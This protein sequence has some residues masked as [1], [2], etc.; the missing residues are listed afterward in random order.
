[1]SQTKI[2][3]RQGPW[4]AVWEG[5]RLADVFH[6]SKPDALDCVQVGEYDFSL[7]HDALEASRAGIGR[8]DVRA[9]LRE[10]VTESGA[11]FERELPYL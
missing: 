4:R 6:A 1:M 11:D 8:Q 7:N 5:G 10:W 9:A 3:V 2:V